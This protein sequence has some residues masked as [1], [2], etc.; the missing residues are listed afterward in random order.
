VCAYAYACVCVCVC[1]RALRYICNVICVYD[2]CVV[3]W[4]LYMCAQEYA[5][6]CVYTCGPEIELNILKSS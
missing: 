5:H 1:V 6:L 4:Y 2:T 3:V